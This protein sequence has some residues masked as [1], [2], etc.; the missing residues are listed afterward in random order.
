MIEKKNSIVGAVGILAGGIIGAG[1]FSLPYVVHQS[2]LLVGLVLLAIAATAYCIIHL[3][4]A[5]VIV[6]TTGQHRFVGYIAKYLGTNW[7]YFAIL[8][9]VVQMVCVLTIYLILSISFMRLIAP[10]ANEFTA[11]FLFW[12]L[13]SATMFLKLRRLAVV[14]TLVT[15]GILAIMVALFIFGL[16]DLENLAATPLVRSQNALLPLAAI[17]FALS[18][19]VAIAPLVNYFRSKDSLPKKDIRRA[20]IAGTLLPAISYAIFI[21]A[22]LALS[23]FVSEDSITGIVAAIPH[24]LALGVGVLGFLTLWSSYILV[25]LDVSDTLKYDLDLP[26]WLRLFVVIIVPLMLYAVGFTSFI[27]LVSIV[28]GVFLAL[29]GVFIVLLWRQARIHQSLGGLIHVSRPVLLF[30]WFVFSAA[31]IG[32]LVSSYS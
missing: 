30:L 22:V 32:A 10:T 23:G 9:A 17:F 29:E 8:M 26:M 19:R 20:V 4:Y 31:L 1:V 21:C 14:E 15:V 5:D 18:G 28:G 7:S 2:G 3:M 25:G 16:G 11:I 24:W 12:A 27:G 6:G 13:G